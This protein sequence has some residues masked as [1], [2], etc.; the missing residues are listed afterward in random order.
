MWITAKA[1]G[2][3]LEVFLMFL[4]YLVIY[5]LDMY[6]DWDVLIGDLREEDEQDDGKSAKSDFENNENRDFDK[7]P[8]ECERTSN[9]SRHGRGQGQHFGRGEQPSGL[10]GQ[11]QIR[12]DGEVLETGRIDEFQRRPDFHHGHA[13]PVDGHRHFL[14]L[15][16]QPLRRRYAP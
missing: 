11:P 3:A 7:N 4:F 6:K 9:P 12:H 10:A 13:H 16:R 5:F 15:P 8:G 1:R 14:G 2:L